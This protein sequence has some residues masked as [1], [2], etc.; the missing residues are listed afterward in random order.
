MPFTI[1]H[2]AAVVFIKNRYLNLSGLILGSMAPDFIYFILFSPSSNFGHTIL[3]TVILNIPL[4]FLINF[5]YY[6]FIKDTFILNLPSCMSKYYTWVIGTRNRITNIKE[7]IIFIY[8]SVIGMMTH[9]FWDS[10]THKTGYFVIKLDFLKE[11]IYLFGHNIYIYKVAQHGGSLLGFFIILIFLYKI[12]IKGV[13]IN[14]PIKRK[15]I[16]H[17]TVMIITIMVIVAAYIIFKDNFGIGR[18]VV[19]FINGLFLGYIG[20]GFVAPKLEKL[21]MM[22]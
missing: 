11:S 12:R 2:P 19:T 15:L 1:A 7:A 10:F 5:I 17:I 21:K 14:V 18:M 22:I 6:E 9:V 16:Y 4:C 20:A 13:K 8:S 3:G